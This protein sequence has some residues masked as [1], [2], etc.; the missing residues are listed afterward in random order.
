MPKNKIQTLYAKTP[1]Q[2]Y[3]YGWTDSAHN[4]HQMKSYKGEAKK[5]F[6]QRCDEAEKGHDINERMTVAELYEK[7]HDSELVKNSGPSDIEQ[8]EWAW[9]RYIDNEIGHMQLADVKRYLLKDVLTKAATSPKKAPKTASKARKDKLLAS[10]EYLSE[11]SL[12]HIRKTITRI[13]NYATLDLEIDI[14]N[15]AIKLPIT[16]KK[17]IKSDSDN[18]GEDIDL[19]SHFVDRESLERLFKVYGNFSLAIE[20]ILYTGMRP[21]EIIGLTWKR[22]SGGYIR[23]RKSIT[24]YGDSGLK[25]DASERDI[26]LSEP[27]IDLLRDQW[28]NLQEKGH[29]HPIYV[30]P[31][32]NGKKPTMAA[33]VSCFNNMKNQTEEWKK[34]GR[35]YH[36]KSL[37]NPVKFTLYDLRHTFATMAARTMAPKKLQYIMGHKNVST[38]LGIYAEIEK[39]SIDELPYD[40]SN[41]W[42]SEQS[43]KIISIE[44][45]IESKKQTA[46]VSD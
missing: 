27:A 11:E 15:P 21:S 37:R 36:G 38:T 29:A 26:P 24:K 43:S 30:F 1:N 41:M 2:I 40:I 25:T 35:K 19:N 10:P 32:A 8:T 18:V 42:G 22:I 45:K 7:W 33:I 13:F 9:N 12:R 6:S 31:L 16:A 46:K 14:N 23:V 17:N 44:D 5:E 4:R 34:I 28:T 20:L 3:R 39:Q